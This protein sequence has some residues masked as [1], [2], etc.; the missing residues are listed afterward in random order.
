LQLVFSPF[1]QKFHCPVMGVAYPP[2]YAKTPR[3]VHCRVP[4]PDALNAA[5]NAQ[6]DAGWLI[7]GIT[8]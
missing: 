5:T 4:K 3:F 6:P 1:G 7:C 2:C 8:H